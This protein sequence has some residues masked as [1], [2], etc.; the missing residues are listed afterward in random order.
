[1]K[2][3]DISEF[4]FFYVLNGDPQRVL[5]PSLFAL[6]SIKNNKILRNR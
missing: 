6:N 5:K 1:M 2:Y 3:E 4:S